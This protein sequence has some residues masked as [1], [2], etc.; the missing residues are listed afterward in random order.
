MLKATVPWMKEHFPVRPVKMCHC[1]ITNA[2][3]CT[4]VPVLCVFT[5]PPTAFIEPGLWGLDERSVLILSWRLTG[6]VWSS[7]YSLYYCITVGRGMWHYINK[8]ELD[9]CT[10]MPSS[11]K[12]TAFALMNGSRKFKKHF[13]R[14]NSQIAAHTWVSQVQVWLLHV[15]ISTS[16][17]CCD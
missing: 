6:V 14:V 11:I 15:Y 10:S 7:G 17:R 13:S 1:T 9:R 16:P 4:T 12:F 8:A 2:G 5:D 3:C